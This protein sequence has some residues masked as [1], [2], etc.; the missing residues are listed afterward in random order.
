MLPHQLVDLSDE[1]ARLRL[2][3]GPL[4]RRLEVIDRLAI[5]HLLRGETIIATAI[6]IEATNPVRIPEKA[7][8]RDV[9][10]VGRKTAIQFDPG[11][12]VRLGCLISTAPR[13]FHTGQEQRAPPSGN[14]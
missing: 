7:A 1:P 5:S 2:I 10:C 9:A 12:I 11:Q 14:C 8:F 3:L 4:Q 6:M 13:R